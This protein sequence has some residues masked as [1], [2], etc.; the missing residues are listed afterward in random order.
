MAIAIS[1][2]IAP[3]H[4]SPGSSGEGE[5][6][7]GRSSTS[8][9]FWP[10]RVWFSDLLSLLDSSPLEIPPRRD[11]LSQVCGSI[12]H[13]RPQLRKLGFVFQGSQ[14]ISLGFS[15]EVGETILHYRAQSTRKLY[16]LMWRLYTSSCRN[17]WTP[18]TA[19]N[20]GIFCNTAILEFLQD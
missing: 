15:T 10:G 14:L 20:T 4:S 13:P 18:L 2:C 12:F 11:L 19:Q 7:W 6:G 8:S 3:N 5:P 16:A 1:V 9:P 17:S